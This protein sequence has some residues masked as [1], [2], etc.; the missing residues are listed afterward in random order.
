VATLHQ[1]LTDWR[2]KMPVVQEAQPGLHAALPAT[3]G[4]PDFHQNRQAL[5]L[6]A[7][8]VAAILATGIVSPL[9]LGVVSGDRSSNI[10]SS[11]GLVLTAAALFAVV[12]HACNLYSK[13]N[14]LS[15]SEEIR[16][17]FLVWIAAFIYIIPL[18]YLL[19]PLTTSPAA[20][21]IL[22]ATTALVLTITRQA[23]R[24]IIARYSSA[25]VHPGCQIFFV[26]QDNRP[27]PPGILQKIGNSGRHVCR[28]ASLP[29]TFD[30]KALST[31]LDDIVD[32]VRRHEVDE[33][34]LVQCQADRKILERVLH[35]LRIVP[36]PVVFIPESPVDIS[37]RKATTDISGLRAIHLRRP[38]LTR[39]QLTAKRLLD[40]LGGTL[41]LLVVLPA[42]LAIAALVHLNSPGPILFRQRRMGLNGRPFYIFKFR[43]MTTLDDGPVVRQ[44]SRD[45]HRITSVGHVL[46][47][48]SLDELPQLFNVLRG[49]MS[50]V[51]PRPHALAHDLE[52]G[53][54]ID[55]YAAR[56]NVKPGITGWAQVNGWRGPTPRLELM[57]RR[58]EHDLWYMD[59]WSL[60]LDIKILF[61]TVR[62]VSNDQNAF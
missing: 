11:L 27:V 46:R 2:R 5:A 52:Y 39:S 33:I 26:T 24:Q 43:T 8:D 20:I 47:R 40:L 54:A 17:V 58:V 25:S 35:H 16:S 18:S 9:I 19:G 13:T 61:M 51:G 4:A 38:A 37:L 48:L 34:L 36:Q 29:A 15:V 57:I 45:D 56:H 12:G 10:G 21:L 23:V 41:A 7:I 42:L 44:A 50:L 49:E 62:S 55:L 30:D 28:T 53:H 59:N 14:T 1:V 31:L 60:W 32:Y 22:F 6:P 3:Q